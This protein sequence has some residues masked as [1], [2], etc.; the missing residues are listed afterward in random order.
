MKSNADS[1]ASDEGDKRE[2]ER[3]SELHGQLQAERTNFA[4][5][6]QQVS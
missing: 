1:T 4:K 5:V 3:N 2:G 6:M